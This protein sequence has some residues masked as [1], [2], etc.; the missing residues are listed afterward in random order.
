MKNDCECEGPCICEELN[1]AVEKFTDFTMGNS[2]MITVEMFDVGIGQAMLTGE[3]IVNLFFHHPDV[4]PNSG[5]GVIAMSFN[6]Q[7]IGKLI[8]LCLRGY[9][10]NWGYDGD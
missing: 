8:N 4:D 6:Q 3:R 9:R 10:E 7:S 1:A 2:S 5:Q